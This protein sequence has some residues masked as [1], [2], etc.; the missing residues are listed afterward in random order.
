MTTAPTRPAAMPSRARLVRA[1]EALL[2]ATLATAGVL[3]L[4]AFGQQV[5]PDWLGGLW[6]LALAVGL[7]MVSAPLGRLGPAWRP[8]VQALAAMTWAGVL[9]LLQAHGWP[10]EGGQRVLLVAV[11]AWALAIWLDPCA[12]RPVA[13]TAGAGRD[14]EPGL[15]GCLRRP[16]RAAGV[17][18]GLAAAAPAL[19]VQPDLGWAI[20]ALAVVI[21][22]QWALRRVGLRSTIGP[23]RLGVHRHSPPS[24]GAASD[25]AARLCG[26]LAHASMLP[27]MATLPVMSG[28]CSAGGLDGTAVLIAHGA[29]MVLPAVVIGLVGAS[30]CGPGR[31]GKGWAVA[32][33][34][35]LLFSAL[36][37]MIWWP[38]LQGLMLAASLQAAAWSLSTALPALSPPT[39]SPAR[40]WAGG[41]GLV[42]AVVGLGL[43]IDALGPAGLALVHGAL[44]L[45]LVLGVGA[46]VL[47][48]AAGAR[49]RAA[50]A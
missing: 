13:C 36:P 10:D 45:A 42:A 4:G 9:G 1:L 11:A 20:A 6:P 12:A 17:G 30:G 7:A 43:V 22:G 28:W 50:G 16:A 34:A 27:M 47:G 33:V 41:L 3:L 25:P 24:P 15:A 29:S 23:R 2:Q 48:R 49:Q 46:V 37:A 19:Q 26:A 18:L 31:T 5:R 21:A 14:E 40:P 32:M 44:A 39:V 35:G 8:R 38:G